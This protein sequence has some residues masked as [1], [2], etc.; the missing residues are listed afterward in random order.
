MH[1]NHKLKQIQQQRVVQH[2]QQ[3]DAYDFFNLLT[4]DELLSVIDSLLPAHRERLY[5]PAE[6]LAMFLAQ[7]MSADGSC[8]RAVNEMTIKRMQL[9]FTRYD[10]W[11]VQSSAQ[12][13]SR[14]GGSV[15]AF[16]TGPY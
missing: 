14:R 3:T 4:S 16:N 10:R 2:K 6:T 7:V 5:P 13:V 11:F 15:A 9:Q 12:T 8:Q 1:P